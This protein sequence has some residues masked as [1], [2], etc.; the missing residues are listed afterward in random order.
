MSRK[1][2]DSGIE[3]IGQIPEDWNVERLKSRFTFG[4]GLPITKEDL[5]KKGIP[6]ISY[7]QIHSKVNVG[8]RIKAELLRYVDEEYLKSNSTSLVN[9]G[10]FI[11]ADTSEDVTGCGNFVYVDSA[12]ILFAGYHTIILKSK[13]DCNNKYLAYLFQTDCWRSQIRSAVLGV[14]LFSVTKKILSGTTLILPSNEEQNRIVNYLDSVCDNIDNTIETHYKCISDYKLYKQSKINE[15]VLRGLNNHTTFR[16]SEID[17]VGEI[18]EHW[19]VVKNSAIFRE[20]IRP[21]EEGD[22][23][24]SLSQVDGLIATA[25]MKENSLKT[26]S[27]ENW[28]RVKKNDLVINRFKAHLGVM[29]AADI[30]GMVS[31]HYGVFEPK[32]KLCSKYYEYLC[33]SSV[34]KTIYGS[35]SNGM[36]VGLQNLSNINF[37]AVKSILP[38]LKEQEE[39]AEYLDKKCV[40]IDNLIAA[41]EK[42]IKELEAYKKSLIY[43]YV[44]GKKEVI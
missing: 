41:K 33:H 37:Y 27:Y 7:G 17:L 22:I 32:I 28:K 14:K 15:V 31:F 44:T 4:K 5:R 30:E 35:M 34:Y 24:L 1:M 29:F 9:I 3:W 18:P 36:V 26:S 23:P 16:D 40:E 8:T 19:K 20:N 42:T 11:F 10:D 2:K 25:D 43:E 38:P 12:D 21:Y 13:R 6:V 39:I